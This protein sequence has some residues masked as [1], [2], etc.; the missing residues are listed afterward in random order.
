[1]KIS[2]R[3]RYGLRLLVELASRGDGPVMVSRLADAQDL[4]PAYA[5]KLVDPLRA[6]GLVRSARGSGGGIRLARPADSISVLEAV[7]ALEGGLSLL[8]CTGGGDTCPR[9][10]GCATRPVWTGLE[11]TVRDYLAGFSLA[12][13]AGDLRGF[14]MSAGI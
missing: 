13:L 9:E 6:A 2:T 1:M 12:T 14:E 7:E 4:P 8:D 10:A 5:A 3:S 11:R